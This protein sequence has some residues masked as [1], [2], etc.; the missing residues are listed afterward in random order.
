MGLQLYSGYSQV[1]NNLIYA[2]VNQGILAN[3]PYSTQITN[4]TIYQPLGDAVLVQGGA[5]GISLDNNILWTQAA[6][7]YDIAVADNSQ[8]GFSSDYNDLMTSGGGQVAFWQD[9]AR[10]TLTAWQNTAFTDQNS[11]AL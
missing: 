8:S 7:T 9:I 6:G 11:L 10:P 4:N 3:G 2:N 5:S 1:S